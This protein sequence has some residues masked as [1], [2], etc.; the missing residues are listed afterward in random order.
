MSFFLRAALAA[1][2][3]VASADLASAATADWSGLYAGLNAG[4]ADGASYVH[5][6]LGG[7][8]FD[9]NNHPNAKGL[10]VGGQAGYNFQDGRWVFGVEAMADFA[11]LTGTATC[12]SGRK[13]SA[14]CKPEINGLGTL[15]ARIGFADGANLFYAKAGGAW[16]DEF[17]SLLIFRD[18]PLNSNDR[19]TR[20]GWT[21]GAGLEHKIAPNWSVKF[22]Y[23]HVGFGGT[24]FNF[25]HPQPVAIDN[26]T[27]ML[28][29]GVN[30]LFG[31]NGPEAEDAPSS[32]EPDGEAHS[33]FALEAALRYFGAGSYMK[34]DFDSSP[35]NENSRIAYNGMPIRA[36][37]L[38][39]RVDHE[40][41]WFVAADF[42][43]GT[44]DGGVQYDEDT[45]H[46]GF[47]NADYSNSVTAPHHGWFAAQSLDFGYN[48]VSRSDLRLG[49]FVGFDHMHEATNGYGCLQIAT[50][51]GTCVPGAF[52]PTDHVFIEDDTWYSGR[53]GINGRIALADRLSFEG[54]V[55][56]LPDAFFHGVDHHLARGII[57]DDRGQGDGVKLDALL[58]YAVTGRI[59]IGVGAR[60]WEWHSERGEDHCIGG[61]CDGA[62]PITTYA[63]LAPHD[64]HLFGGFAQVSYR[65]GNAARDVPA[66][67]QSSDFA[68]DWTGFYGGVVTGARQSNALWRTTCAENPCSAGETFRNQNLVPFDNISAYGGG[69]GGYS[70]EIAPNWIAGVEGD[71]GWGNNSRTGANVWMNYDPAPVS[72]N[73]TATISGDVDGSVRL[74]AGYLVTPDTLAY[75]TGGLSIAGVS[76]STTCH[77]PVKKVVFWCE[78]PTSTDGTDATLLGWTVGLGAETAL[79]PE[80]GMRAE[81]RYSDDG[82]LTHTF[83]ADR[84]SDSVTA[85]MQ[86]RDSRL[87]LGLVYYLR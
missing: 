63:W 11:S 73:D 66:D 68:F 32:I 52:L 59:S 37:E 35:A 41:G 77:G 85:K 31:P 61:G 25:A 69:L 79:T 60:Y 82:A 53:I 15:A 75:L 29:V 81:Y 27:D 46:A 48:L 72:P 14:R 2:I 40:T 67:T 84:D 62:A 43:S 23:D 6:P 50:N 4:G 44:M 17:E 70:M 20:L 19:V 24:T 21:A 47:G 5:N 34:K 54:Q 80:L 58:N 28:T 57:F 76:A 71:I 1:G 26:D 7:L 42:V 38:F 13:T 22:E 87:L 18:P 9:I 51:N 33:P 8:Q 78:G 65:V 83:F 10:L 49:V 16:M 45:P 64:A 39:G 30:Y 55:V 3:A 74:R 36:A 86:M 12:L 56:Y